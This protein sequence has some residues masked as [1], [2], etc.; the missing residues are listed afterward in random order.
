[1]AAIPVVA[2]CTALAR[3]AG[4]AVLAMTPLARAL[5]RH[6]SVGACPPLWI[7][8]TARA[9]RLPQCGGARGVFSAAIQE[10]LQALVSRHKEVSDRVAGGATPAAELPAL[11]RELHQLERVAAAVARY[12]QLQSEAADLAAVIAEDDG[13]A[14]AGELVR[15]AKE[16]A[17]GVATA[18]EEAEATLKRLMLPKDEADQRDAILELRAGTGGD[19]AAIFTAEVLAMYAAF[20]A[21]KGW[22]WNPLSLSPSD[23]DGL[24]EA[25]VGVS[26]AGAYGA[27]KFEA[28]VHRV[29]RVPVTEGG[30]RVHTSTMSV[31]VLPEADEI[32]VVIRPQDLRIDTYRAQGAGGQ[33]VNTT[34]SA[35]RITHL[36]TGVVTA[37][38]DERSQHSNKTKAMRLLRAKLFDHERERQEAAR[39]AS[40]RSQIGRAE[41]SERIRTYN[42]NQ[43]R[44]TD[45]RIAVTK[46]APDQ[47]GGGWVGG[48]GGGGVGAGQARGRGCVPHCCRTSPTR[49]P[50]AG[51]TWRP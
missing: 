29:Q 36:P 9:P 11:G 38:Q 34:D 30:G 46:C 32:D 39:A 22:G 7:A 20:A 25:V 43:N 16:E 2:R 21:A 10:R 8:R 42:F 33:H 13:S 12:R 26:G 14:A 31:A 37:C 41:R 49:G 24:K 17:A 35:V 23:H 45:H 48:G 5:A 1:M 44:V 51:S 27:L 47:G 40:R 3:A 50:R 18:V 6:A 19:E 4:A 28:G 15:M